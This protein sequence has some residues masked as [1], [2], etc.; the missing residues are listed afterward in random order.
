MYSKIHSTTSFIFWT[1]QHFLLDFAFS[2][3]S[4]L[5]IYRAYIYKLIALTLYMLSLL[6]SS[7]S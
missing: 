1:A 3:D 5:N 6:L 2:L 4:A 7:V